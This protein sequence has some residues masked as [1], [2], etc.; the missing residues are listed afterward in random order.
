[1]HIGAT[2]PHALG[3]ECQWQLPHKAQQFNS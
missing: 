1:M 3:M 2:M